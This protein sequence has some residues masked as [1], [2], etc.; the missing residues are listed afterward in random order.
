MEEFIATFHI[1]WKLMLAQVFNFGLVFLALY[2]L[3]SK[4][5]SKLIK[6]RTEEITKGLLDAENNSKIKKEMEIKYNEIITEAKIKADEVFKEIKNE[7]NAKKKEILEETKIEVYTMIENGKKGLEEE[8][9]KMVKEA[10]KEI[11]SLIIKTTE[12]ILNGHNLLS[13]NEKIT[14]ELEDL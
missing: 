7:A 14:K 1:D 9:I 8:K 12:K 3:A 10:K 13:L 4:P 6:E 2:F 5:L 11:T